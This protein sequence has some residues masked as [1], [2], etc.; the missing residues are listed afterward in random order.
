MRPNNCFLTRLDEIREVENMADMASTIKGENTITKEGKVTGLTVERFF[1]TPGKHPFNK[2]K[3][4][5]RDASIKDM[6]GNVVFSQ[7]GVEV[8][9][10]WSQ[11]ATH[12]VVSKYFR[13]KLGTDRREKSAK[14]LINRVSKTIAGWGVEK[15]YFNTT[16]DGD[17]FENELT[18][19]LINQAAAFNS[20][21]W[22]N[23]G[24]ETKPQCSA[25]F[26]NSVEDNMESILNL[27]VTEGMLFKYG[28]GTGS[29]LS[30]LRSS[31]ELLSG[32]GQSSGPLSFMKGFDSFAG[33]IKS[34]GKT[35]R[36]AKMVIL[37][38]DNVT[39]LTL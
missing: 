26:I 6:S 18:H 4:E 3:W 13:G 39:I 36:A 22:F 19:I 33:A 10:F 15:G 32:G 37:N 38:Y 20:P 21:V 23:V 28:S 7:Q 14:Q 35:R 34:G 25:C 5:L 8:P 1:T 12:I 29:N 17:S 2:I 11:T 9:S 30:V 31:K 16:E 24:V 27:A